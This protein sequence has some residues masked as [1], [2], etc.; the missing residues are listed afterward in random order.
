MLRFIHLRKTY[1]LL[2]LMIV[3]NG[4]LQLLCVGVVM[5]KSVGLLDLIGN[6][7]GQMHLSFLC[8]N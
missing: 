2:V 1:P 8:P 5:G 4:I 7:I 6:F 3:L